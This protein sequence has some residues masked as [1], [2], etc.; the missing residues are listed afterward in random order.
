MYYQTNLEKTFCIITDRP[1]IVLIKTPVLTIAPRTSE[2]ISLQFRQPLITS[3]PLQS[4]QP[5][6]VFVNNRDGITEECFSVL[7]TKRETSTL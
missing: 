6:H 2:F 5:T 3:Q 4:G 7:V 1:D